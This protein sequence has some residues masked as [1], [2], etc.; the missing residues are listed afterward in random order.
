MNFPALQSLLRR[1]SEAT[2]IPVTLRLGRAADFPA[3]RDMAFSEGTSITVAPRFLKEPAT[4]QGAVLAHELAHCV[5][6]QQDIEHSER[7]ADTLGEVIGGR[8]IAYD[9]RDVQTWGAGQRPR[10]SY[11]PR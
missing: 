1:W 11:L 3:A 5:L 9:A 4:T 10:P 7:D 8:P 2:G 6:L